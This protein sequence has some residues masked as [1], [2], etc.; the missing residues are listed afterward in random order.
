M[1]HEFMYL[2]PWTLQEEVLRSPRLGREERL[3]KAVLAFKL[4]LHDFELSQMICG[5]GV[6]RRYIS[7]KTVAVTFAEDSV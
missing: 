1:L 7:G 5:T 2:M 4:L 3:V 6:S